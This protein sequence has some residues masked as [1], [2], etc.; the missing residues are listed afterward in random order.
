MNYWLV[1]IVGVMANMMTLLPTGMGN[2]RT[3]RTRPQS[4]RHVP[5]TS[6]F[7]HVYPHLSSTPRPNNVVSAHLQTVSDL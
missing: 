5:L 2:L 3:H 7:Y 1:L 4:P 6:I